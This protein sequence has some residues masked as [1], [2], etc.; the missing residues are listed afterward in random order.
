MH[1]PSPQP[2]IKCSAVGQ[3]RA[4]KPS[5]LPIQQCIISILVYFPFFPHIISAQLIPW[6]LLKFTFQI[7]FIYMC[8][9]FFFLKTDPFWHQGERS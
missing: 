2:S 7:F 8:V 4:G 6:H 3:L 5:P 1:L 9:T